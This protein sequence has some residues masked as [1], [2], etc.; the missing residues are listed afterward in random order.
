MRIYGKVITL[1]GELIPIKLSLGPFKTLCYY[2]DLEEGKNYKSVLFEGE[3]H[4]DWKPY[5]VHITEYCF[6]DT[7]T[8]IFGDEDTEEFL[9]SDGIQLASVEEGFKHIIYE[10]GIQI[11]GPYFTRT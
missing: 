4:T 11:K 1:D 9:D 6:Y 2:M 10:N 8:G 5:N 7:K 3:E